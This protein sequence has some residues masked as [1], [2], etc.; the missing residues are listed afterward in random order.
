[1]VVQTELPHRNVRSNSREVCGDLGSNA[2]SVQINDLYV[3]E[4]RIIYAA[5]RFTGGLYVLELTI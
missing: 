5:D 2:G 3:D 1:M 4:N